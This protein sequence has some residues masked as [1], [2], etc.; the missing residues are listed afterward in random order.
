[1]GSFLNQSSLQET[2]ASLPAGG[3]AFWQGIENPLTPAGFR[4]LLDEYPSLDLFEKHEG[5]PRGNGQRPHDRYY[6]G[7]KLSRYHAPGYRG[8]GIAFPADLAPSWRRFL[9]EIEGPA[10]RDFL[11]DVLG[12][13][14]FA[15]R[16]A[17]HMG[18]TG[19][20][21]SPHRDTMRK[22]SIQLFYFNA[23]EVWQ[24]DWG[25]DLLILNDRLVDRENPEFSDFREV[26][27]VSA[28]GNRSALCRNGPEAWH[29]V[30][31]LDCPEG[32][33]RRV[34][35]VIAMAPEGVKRKLVLRARRLFG[36]GSGRRA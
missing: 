1:M 11:S 15:L 14:R 35:S 33:Y 2:K 4:T 25:G 31:P 12:T 5:L 24:R 23:P 16:C 32:H 27:P 26:I 7:Y 6:L 13:D 10:Y 34:F 3:R 21:V 19:A 28:V 30:K 29:G 20:E 36:I 9:D 8:P 18:M 22:L 17:W